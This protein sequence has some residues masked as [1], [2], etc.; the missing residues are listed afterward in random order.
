MTSSVQL[1]IKKI[2]KANVYEGI[3]TVGWGGFTQIMLIKQVLSR[4]SFPPC[5]RIHCTQEIL[6]LT[7]NL[8][9]YFQK[10]TAFD[11]L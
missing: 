2:L 8:G 1:E 3:L 11:M 6:R 9:E 5:T 4:P 7:G 10:V